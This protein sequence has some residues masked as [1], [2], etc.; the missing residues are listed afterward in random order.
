V[1]ADHAEQARSDRLARLPN[2]ELVLVLDLD[3]RR[4]RCGGRELRGAVHLE[5]RDHVDIADRR[6]AITRR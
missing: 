4:R 1:A 6:A 3:G 2:V 5:A